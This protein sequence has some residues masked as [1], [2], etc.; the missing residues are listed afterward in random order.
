MDKDTKFARRDDCELTHKEIKEE[1]KE[2]RA[3]LGSQSSKLDYMVG[4]IDGIDSQKKS[5][6]T[7]YGVLIAMAVGFW[8]LIKNI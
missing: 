8:N 4:K 6:I 7:F 3:E 2:I 1:F 5:D